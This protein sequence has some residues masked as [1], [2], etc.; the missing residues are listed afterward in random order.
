MN[1][2]WQMT[3]GNGWSK[4]NDSPQGIPEEKPKWI[5]FY[6]GTGVGLHPII[7]Y[8]NDIYYL[9]SDEEGSS[10]SSLDIDTGNINW[11][12]GQSMMKNVIPRM[13]SNS[14]YVVTPY[15]LIDVSGEEKQCF[16]SIIDKERCDSDISFML[17]ENFITRPFDYGINSNKYLTY[18]IRT[19]KLD[20]VS[21]P[22]SY[23]EMSAGSDLVYGFIQE[24]NDKKYLA[25]C[26]LDGNIIW[27]IEAPLGFLTLNQELVNFSS[28][29]ISVYSK[30]DGILIKRMSSMENKFSEEDLDSFYKSHSKDTINILS[31][32]D[33]SIYS[34]PEDRMLAKIEGMDIHDYCVSGDII[35]TRQGHWDLAAY[36]RYVGEE[37]W[38]YSERY[39]WQS[40]IAS[41]NK[42]IVYCATGD[43]VCFNC[44]EAYV[45]PYK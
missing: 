19:K 24:N 4:Y 35:F 42:L 33:L 21:L 13:C 27:K 26:S 5:R 16:S 45:S 3:H 44:G 20:V 25:C 38:R 31:K 7:S 12:Y 10:L 18:E 15:K 9:S 34:I 22:V 32:G 6:G 23:G 1:N 39:A 17:G 2:F 29:N 36:D 14:Q 28:E 8:L 11:S 37:I 40:L 43:I 41:N 30:K